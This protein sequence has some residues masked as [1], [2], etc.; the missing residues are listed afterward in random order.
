MLLYIGYPK[1]SIKRL[2]ELVRVFCRVTEHKMYEHKSMV[3]AYP[4]NPLSEIE[5]ASRVSFKIVENIK[6][7]GINLMKEMEDLYDKN[8]KKF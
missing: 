6:Y 2:L 5:L 1:D 7:F 8:H 4:T 3:L